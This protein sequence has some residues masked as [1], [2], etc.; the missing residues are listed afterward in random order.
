VGKRASR[1]GLC[2]QQQMQDRLGSVG[3]SQTQVMAQLGA[4]LI[5][6]LF[7]K[8]KELE[9][10]S[11]NQQI[12]LSR[13]LT[14]PVS[15]SNTLMVSF[16]FRVVN[17]SITKLTESCPTRKNKQANIKHIFHAVRHPKLAILGNNE[18]V[19]TSITHSHTG[20]VLNI[21]VNLRSDPLSRRFL[22]DDI[23]HTG[24]QLCADRLQDPIALEG[25]LD[26]IDR[27]HRRRHVWI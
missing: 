8:K 25:L 12:C 26:G 2:I 11:T 14:L 5:D 18:R 1:G 6:I 20:L 9:K 4:I 23:E 19:P 3:I 21:V 10:Q 17:K 16:R 13:V 24:T 22:G 15:I 7:C 27:F